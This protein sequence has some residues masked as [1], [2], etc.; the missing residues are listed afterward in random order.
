MTPAAVVVSAA[1]AVAVCVAACVAVA[2]CAAVAACVVVGVGVGG[3]A[4]A[5]GR[6]K[7]IG[8]PVGVAV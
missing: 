2:A 3:Y 7:V 8:I 1:V 5:P 6:K 4:V